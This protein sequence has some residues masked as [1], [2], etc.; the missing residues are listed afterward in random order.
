MDK[1][2]KAKNLIGDDFFR[3][4]MEALKN[5]ELERIVNSSPDEV[6]LREIAYMRINALQSVVAH[7]QSMAATAEIEKKRWK[8]L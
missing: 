5:V 3:D 2:Q 7:F 1:V 6:E 4:E 8:I